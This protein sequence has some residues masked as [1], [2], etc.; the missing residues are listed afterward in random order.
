MLLVHACIVY[1]FTVFSKGLASYLTEVEDPDVK[2]I[3]TGKTLILKVI[4]VII[5]Q[6]LILQLEAIGKIKSQFC[7]EWFCS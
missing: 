6:K 3:N 5:I 7:C 4:L 2:T 1:I